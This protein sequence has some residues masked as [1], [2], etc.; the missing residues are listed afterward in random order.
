VGLITPGGPSHRTAVDPEGN[1]N[2]TTANIS[3]LSA[4]VHNHPSEG[5]IA[6][7][8][9]GQTPDTV[10]DFVLG[11]FVVEPNRG[12]QIKGFAPDHR[13]HRRSAD[14]EVE[15][16]AWGL[17]PGHAWLNVALGLN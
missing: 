1:G 5:C 11:D 17:L 14:R 10:E 3:A 7:F 6:P 8:L 13:I 2:G 12:N 15:E 9:P 4:F 16:P